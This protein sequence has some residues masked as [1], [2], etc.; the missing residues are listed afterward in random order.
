MQG[1][2]FGNTCPLLF[3]QWC[4]GFSNFSFPQEDMF[5]IFSFVFA[6]IQQIMSSSGVNKS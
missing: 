2:G 1:S 6:R 3:Q 5:S 4:K